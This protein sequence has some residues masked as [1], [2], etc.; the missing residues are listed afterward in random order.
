M[1]FDPS[2]VKSLFLVAADMAEPAE[3][4]AYLAR[5]CGD[6]D[7][8]RAR[9]E[10]LL[11]ADDALPP[12]GDAARKAAP[13]DP[14]PYI[15]QTI[16]GRYKVL[17]RIGEGGMG[18]VFMALQAEPVRRAVAL[19]IVK[20]GMDSKSVLARFEAERQALAM[21]DHPNIARVFDAGTTE[22]GTPF[23]VMELVKGV[24]ITQYCDRHKLTL[25]Q[26]LELFVPVC[27][28]IQ[29]AH[30]KG[31]IHRDIKPSNVLV[32][33][34]DDRAVPKVID[35]GVAKA[36]GRSLTEETL[37]TGFA[38]L[39]GTLEYMS[40]EQ[41]S[42]NNLDIDT[43]SDV[44]SLGVL[45]YEL[46]TG[47]TPLDR[48]SLGKAAL[49]DMLRIVREVDAP[50]PSAKLSSS[51]ALPSLA[52]DRNTEPA[53]LTKLMQG[54]IDWVLLKALEKD[55]TRRYETANSLARDIQRYLANDVVEARPPSAGYRIGKFVRRHKVEVAAA[56]LLLVALLAGIGGTTFGL[57]RADQQRRI[58][59]RALSEA[60]E[61]GVQ[62]KNRAEGE[63]LAKLDAEAKRAEAERQ[64]RRAWAGEKLAGLRL[65]HVEEEKRK[66][67]EEKKE[68]EAQQ[69][70][71][72]A[73]RNF[74]QKLLRQTDPLIQANALLRAG[75]SSAKTESNP[76]IRELLDRSALEL[77]PE[78]IEASF[79]NQP[80]LQAELLKTVGDT[81]RGVG[82]YDRAIALLVR[83]VDLWKGHL[84][85]DHPDT[86]AALSALAAA[87]LGAGKLPQAIEI[88]ERLR[89]AD[90]KEFGPDRAETLTALNGLAMAYQAAGKLP[91]AMEIFE[92]VR[93][94]QVK[95]LGV[96]H[97]NTLITLNNLAL[98]CLAAGGVPQ[99]IQ[100][101][102][103]VHDAQVK[104]LG[105]DHPATLTTLGNLAAAHRAAGNL[106]KAVELLERVRDAKT[107]KLG[108]D[109][110]STLDT[111][112]HLA[113]AYQA[114]GKLP[115]AIALLEH[116]RDVE[117][118]KLGNDHPFTLDT[119]GHLA[120]AYQAAG[121]LPEAL[122]LFEQVRDRFAEK[123]GPDH[124]S[125]LNAVNNLA[126]AYYEDGDFPRAADLLEQVRD[127]KLRRLGAGHLSTLDTVGRLASAYQASGRLEQ[128]TA[129]FEQVRDGYVKK[130]GPENPETLGIVNNLANAYKAKG[131]LTEA[132]ALFEQVRDVCAKKLGADHVNTLI[133]LRNLAGA[134][135][136]AGRRPEAIEL[137]ERVR[138]AEAKKFGADHSNT[139][140][141]LNNLAAAYQE[142]G[143]LS[144]AIKLFEQVRDAEVKK[145]G[146]DHPNTLMTINDL[147][148]AY[149]AAGKME[150]ALHLFD[151]AAA[152][153]KR[154]RYL[155]YGA[156]R[157]IGNTIAAYE[158]AGQLDKAELWRRNWLAAVK[159]KFGA[160][161]P[162]YAGELALL[163]VN[164]MHQR[165]HAD[166]EV[167]FR[168]YLDLSQN[169]LAKRQAAPWQVASVKSMLGQ[170]L[171][172]QDD[173]TRAEPLLIAGYE[174]LKRN[175]QAIPQAARQGQMAGAI[176]GLIDLARATHKPDEMKR[177][178][179]ELAKY[180]AQTPA[181]KN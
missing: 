163:G 55:R 159:E 100:Y 153:V 70:I 50:R 123:L 74:L 124:L 102:Q 126:M 171:L 66:V 175:A 136:A 149:Q 155:H 121:R 144:E 43:R 69:H 17:E 165:K 152:G 86:L 142:T 173:S 65:K 141:T 25:R 14:D 28:A 77:A 181:E 81:Y 38:A 179:A 45:L 177:W 4:A 115:E 127:V 84:A 113:R 140:V 52:A 128:A 47:S 96:E 68:V 26:R 137:F 146:A 150:Q 1:A 168:Q 104:K 134:Y 60:E 174:D 31:V 176:Q 125:T 91:Q 42:L 18:S 107:E 93:D 7:A 6:D 103:Q 79:P 71:A 114:A 169:L 9:V 130:L 145:L 157:I 67:E 147:A 162:A 112:G 98:A 170:T 85:P 59:Q 108:A 106:P 129:L 164:L 54:E 111:L 39:V 61:A 34:F 99:A 62:E 19:K 105:A 36:A 88:F 97:P 167:V 118:K 180:A 49:A 13:E 83:A 15:G 8:L 132:I 53:R 120:R 172:G 156:A 16:A 151:Q 37:M 32:A 94:I 158:A 40:P 73:V 95:T 35:F 30:Q 76:T 44:Y 110:P 2:R 131:R 138:D 101:L 23:F 143:R 116:M 117:E 21:M 160:G 89:D 75:E 48:K 51:H 10:S 41:A 57:V 56:A 122:A 80:L 24:P 166:A 29:H 46:L 154:R 87:Y 178:Q 33:L 78:R 148:A 58:A 64:E 161:S 135:Q 22:S 63:R 139:L 12:Q 90:V 3:R 82:E 109:H 72:Q 11:K 92:H 5:E 119:L 20:P 133:V 27:H